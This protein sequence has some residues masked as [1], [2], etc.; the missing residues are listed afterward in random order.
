MRNTMIFVM[1]CGDGR[2]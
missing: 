2:F 1:A